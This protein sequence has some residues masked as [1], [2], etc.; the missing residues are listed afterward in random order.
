MIFLYVLFGLI[1]LIAIYF[2]QPFSMLKSDFNK[3]S[4]ELISQVKSN[5]EVFTAKDIEHLP[6]PLKNYIVSCGFIGKPKMTYIK[7]SF[8][9][10]AFGSGPNQP[11]LKIDY[12]QY[13]IVKTPSRIAFIDSSMFGIPFQG[14]DSYLNGAGRIHGVIAKTFTLFD[15]T[16]DDMDQ[17][18][19]ATCLSEGIMIPSIFLQDYIKYEEIDK[20]HVKATISYKNTSASGIFT[21]NEKGEISSFTTED[22]TYAD[23]QGNSKKVKWT[24]VC[25]EYQT[26]N[27]I[28]QPKSLK[29]V[30]S[31]PEGNYTYFDSDNVTIEYH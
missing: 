22:R 21:F 27:G 29:A 5:G 2:I 26:Q 3:E 14:C 7:A 8:K 10:V 6:T 25:S 4:H 28:K 24:A 16:G 31:L 11:K 19:I 18:S 30:W 20:I 9:N 17:S 13:N 12:T 1:L 15:Q 23:F